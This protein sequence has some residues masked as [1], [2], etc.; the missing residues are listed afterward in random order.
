[1][2]VTL[3]PVSASTGR[4]TASWGAMGSAD[5]VECMASATNPQCAY[6]A[7]A[8]RT[9][10]AHAAR[11]SSVNGTCVIAHLR[12][13]PH[14]TDNTTTTAPQALRIVQPLH[15]VVQHPQRRH[16]RR[17][18]Q[19]Q[20]PIPRGAHRVMGHAPR[21]WTSAPPAP[22]L[23]RRRPLMQRVRHSRWCTIGMHCQ[24]RT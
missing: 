22:A 23:R 5:D 2:W 13:A 11:C 8:G 20:C 3:A 10:S 21:P 4:S 12:D 6:L 16:L 7:P 1:M 19:S 9:A 14:N 24:P 17:C 15:R 18:S